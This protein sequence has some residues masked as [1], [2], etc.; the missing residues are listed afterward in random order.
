MALLVL[1]AMKGKSLG[2]FKEILN[3]SQNQILAPIVDWNSR[4]F[5]VGHWKGTNL[6]G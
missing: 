2:A 1:S 5:E 6:T 4:D 3:K